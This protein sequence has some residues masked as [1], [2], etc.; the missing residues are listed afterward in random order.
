[1]SEGNR[2]LVSFSVGGLSVSLWENAIDGSDRTFKSVT[3]RKMF[4]KDG[5]ADSRSIT[6]NPAEIGC[7]IGL[8]SRMESQVIECRGHRQHSDEP[9]PE[10]V[11]F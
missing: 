10:K 8:L 5:Q 7:M 11:P 6:I 1:M 9:H 3:V 4:N 2:P